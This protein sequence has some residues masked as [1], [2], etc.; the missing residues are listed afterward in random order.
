[1][2]E[3]TELNKIAEQ[4]PHLTAEHILSDLCMLH[5]RTG[6]TLPFILECSVLIHIRYSSVALFTCNAKIL[7]MQLLQVIEKKIIPWSQ[8]GAAERIIVARKH[9]KQAEVPTGVELTYRKIPGR[10]VI[11]KGGRLYGNTR[12]IS[13]QWPEAGMHEVEHPHFI[14]VVEGQAGFQAG[15]YLLGC[16]EGDFIL[17]PPHLPHMSDKYSSSLI[18]SRVPERP[19]LLIWMRLYRRGLQCWLSSYKGS[20]RIGIPTENYL[21]LNGRTIELFRLLMEEALE[22]NNNQ[23]CTGVLLAFSTALQREIEAKRYLHPGPIVSANVVPPVGNDFTG[24]LGNYIQQHL[25]QSLTLEQ[26]AH[27]LFMSRAQLARRIRK[28]CG[29][30]FVELLTEY[31]MK[32]AQTLLRESEW[33]AQ[34]IAQFIGFKSPT[35]FHGL[36]FRQV[37]CTPNEFRLKHKKVH[38]S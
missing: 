14:C 20:Q 11:V 22:E 9:M 23:I 31:R 8:T 21:F 1:M 33:T 3:G 34:T 15:N 37:G 32:E 25:D 12:H 26:V 10:R 13:A 2:W 7:F 5:C 35:Y 17:L 29:Q 24:Q 4:V 6:F 18:Y 27:G 36:F 16:N 30:T 38:I 28:E 19:C